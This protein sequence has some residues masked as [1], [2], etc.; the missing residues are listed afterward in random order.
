MNNTANSATTEAAKAE[1]ANSTAFRA[2]LQKVLALTKSPVEGEAQAAALRLQELCRE[3][4]IEVASIEEKGAKAP[5][6]QKQAHDLG[7]AAFKWK[8]NLAEKIAEHFFCY[9]MVCHY[10]KTVAFVGRPDN[11]EAMQ[12]LYGWLIEQIKQVSATARKEHHTATGE[13]V[14]PLRWQVNFGLGVVD[15]LG[16]R[17]EELKR[18]QQ[19]EAGSAIVLHHASEISDWMEAQYGRRVDGRETKTQRERRERNEKEQTDWNALLATDP[20]AAYAQRPW[21]RPE[22]EEQKAE[23]EARWAKQVKEADARDRKNEARRQAR[24]PRYR[25]VSDEELTKENQAYTARGAGQ[26]AAKDLNLEPFLKDKAAPAQGI[27]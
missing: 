15:R 27:K 24:G 20:E 7:K 14:D 17:L 4:N 25:H 1:K 23:R 21:E 6:I 12:M 22:T 11:V 26:K 3:Y 5:E 9:A 13:H 16:E 18:R 8:L 2:K 19:D 10:S